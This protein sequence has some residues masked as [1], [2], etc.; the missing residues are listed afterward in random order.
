MLYKRSSFITWL[1]KEYECEVSFLP[2]NP[3]VLV[4]KHMNETVKMFVN[5]KDAIPYEEIHLHCNRLGLPGL[6]G[7]KDLVIYE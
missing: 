7:D 4:V 3:R 2:N 6:P 5:S 1:T